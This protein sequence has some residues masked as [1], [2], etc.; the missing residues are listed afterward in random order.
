MRNGEME[1]VGAGNVMKIGN[2]P[3]VL[4]YKAF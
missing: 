1:I 3:S 2:T 4:K